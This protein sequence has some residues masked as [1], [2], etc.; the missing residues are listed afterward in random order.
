MGGDDLPV[1]SDLWEVDVMKLKIVVHEAEE[2]GYWATVPALPGCV[3]EGDTR[4]ELLANIREA[5]KC[6]LDVPEPPLPEK[7]Q[8]EEV[9]V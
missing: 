2:G 6:Y 8:V 9:E 1:N 4:E 3:S 5:I 7:A